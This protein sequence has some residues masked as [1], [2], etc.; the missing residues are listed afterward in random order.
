MP[1]TSASYDSLPYDSIPYPDTHPGR[2]YTLAKLF[3][4]NPTPITRCRVLELGCAAGGNIVPIAESLGDSKFIGVDLSSRQATAGQEWIRELGFGNVEV[5]HASITDVD[6]S[7]GQFDYIISHG[8][9]SWVPNEVQQKMFDICAKQLTPNGIAYISYNVYPGWHMRGMVRDMMRYHAMRFPDPVKRI[10]Q[11]RALLDFLVSASRLQEGSAFAAM[12]KNEL[13]LLRRVSD[14]YLYHDHLAEVN[15]PL[16]FHEFMDRAMKHGLKYLGEARI[17]LMIPGNLGPEVEKSLKILGP[18]LLEKEQFMDFVRNRTF[19]QT[20]LIREGVTPNYN[21]APSAVWD[22]HISSPGRPASEAFDDLSK[23]QPVGFQAPGGMVLTTD[24]PLIRAAMPLLFKAYPGTVYFAQLLVTA[25]ALVEKAGGTVPVAPQDGLE[26]AS[27]LLNCLIGS[28]LVDLFPV[29]QHV[30]RKPPERPKAPLAAR[31]LAPRFR[32]VCN[33]RHEGIMLSEFEQR[34]LP[35][36]TGMTAMEEM[37]NDLSHAA[38]AGELRME[39]DGQPIYDPTA[40]RQL[41]TESVT[42][43]LEKFGEFGLLM[44]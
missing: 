41:M 5:R 14:S 31:L 2:L 9:Y 8:V 26:L 29:A 16:Y 18:G 3:G 6:E 33:V 12:L 19:R 39:K 27:G 7:Y 40:V 30:I 4:L 20:L 11:A 35:L 21:I 25:K 10:E 44:A 34:V 43:A 37:V 38:L 42:K 23:V 28:N 1:P 17:G 36:C 32:V 13:D 24:R 22:M 15:E